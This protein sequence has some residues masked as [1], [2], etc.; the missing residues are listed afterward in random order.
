MATLRAHATR[1]HTP[2][3]V[4]GVNSVNRYRK[5]PLHAAC[6]YEQEEALRALLEAGACVNQVDGMGFTPL[7]L[8]CT[9]A[10]KGE[11]VAMLLEA[12]ANPNAVARGGGTPLIRAV[13][14]KHPSRAM[15]EGLIRGGADVYLA[16]GAGK[17]AYDYAMQ[18]GHTGIAALIAGEMYAT[19][20][21]EYLKAQAQAE[22]DAAAGKKGKKGKKGSK[23]KGSKKKGSK[24]GSKKGK[25]KGK[26]GDEEAPA[27][28]PPPPPLLAG[29]GAMPRTTWADKV[30]REVEDGRVFG[31]LVLSDAQAAAIAGYKEGQAARPWRGV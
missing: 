16:T 11:T 5:A 15:V 6:M 27:K 17:T 10:V 18:W 22:E 23:K 24:K 3:G 29:A 20:P 21:K 19:R 25:G 26:G 7:H 2:G 9:H 1:A 12:G 4:G 31:E 30:V 28:P 8:A 14:R 13:D